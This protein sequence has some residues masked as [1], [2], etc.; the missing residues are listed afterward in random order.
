MSVCFENSS[1][2][3]NYSQQPKCSEKK[4]GPIKTFSNLASFLSSPGCKSA[5]AT[6]ELQTYLGNMTKN[7][8][9]NISETTI[10]SLPTHAH[11]PV[12]VSF[13]YLVLPNLMAPPL[14]AKYQALATAS[15]S[16]SS[17]ERRIRRS[18]MMKNTKNRDSI[19]DADNFR[20]FLVKT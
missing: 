10:L 15:S 17:Q 1:D 8:Q 12:V 11:A 4:F 3:L 18:Q 5:A 14:L 19:L 2:Q 13:P 6:N 20:M 7:I 9:S 16:S